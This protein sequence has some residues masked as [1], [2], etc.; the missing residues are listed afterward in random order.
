MKLIVLPIALLFFPAIAWAQNGTDGEC[1][2]D[3]GNAQISG[4]LKMEFE[5]DHPAHL[6]GY[7]VE[8]I[9][10]R[11]YV[12]KYVNSHFQVPEEETATVSVDTIQVYFD[13]QNLPPD[14]EKLTRDARDDG[15]RWARLEKW[16]K[17][18]LDKN[19][20]VFGN[21]RSSAISPH[22]FADP[23]LKI[24]SISL[25]EISP[26]TKSGIRC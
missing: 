20:L 17:A 10:P 6:T 15:S 26:K 14:L 22:A 7:V 24:I 18:R 11:C 21:I 16:L 3:G 23:G 1:L 12:K 19:V 9:R 13:D 8:L 5:K 25:C 4:R 2:V